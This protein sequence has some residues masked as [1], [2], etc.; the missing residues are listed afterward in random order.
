MSNQPS[1]RKT[2]TPSALRMTQPPAMKTKAYTY[3]V[4]TVNGNDAWALFEACARANVPAATALMKKDRRLVNAQY[5]YR[6][7]IHLAV[8][9]GNAELVELLLE[10]GADPGQSIYTYDSWPKLLQCAQERGDRSVESLLT[11]AM[12]ARFGYDPEFETLKEAIIA[13]D[14]RMI[15]TVLRQQPNL[16]R[17]SDALGNN[18]LHW[19]AITRQ[20]ELIR[21]FVELGTPIDA[22]RA[23]GHT[24]VLLAVNGATDYWHRATRGRSHPSLRNTSVIVGSLLALGADYS[25]S[26]AAAVG[27]Q[28]R[29]EEL[30]RGEPEL[31]T[32]LDSARISPLSHAAREGHLHLVRLLLEHGAEPNRPEEAAP[33]GR[34]LFEACLGNHRQVAELLLERGADPDAGVD[35]SGCCLTIGAVYHGDQAKPIERLLRQ[36]GAQT[37]PYVMSASQ[38]KQAIRDNQEMTQHGEF[39]GCV[40]AKR[41]PALLDL[42]LDLKHG[43]PKGK[44]PARPHFGAGFPYPGRPSLIRQLLDRGLDPNLPDWLGKSFLH[45]SAEQGDRSGAAMLL[46]AGA[47]INAREIEF[48]GTPLAAAVRAWCNETDSEHVPRRRRMVEFLLKRGAATNLPGEAPWSTPL[49]WATRSGKAEIIELLTHHGAT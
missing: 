16:G 29:V 28:E 5:W 21:R 30:L 24:P 45:A 6:F 33:Q 23:D 3:G 1:H 2:R 44:G 17:A 39:L 4:E 36:H 41:D 37:P 11:R 10:N 19:S 49:A 40:L 14:P 38:L 43:S 13:R 18:A 22:K 27:D 15:G 20:L 25:I 32:R 47:D 8:F 46:E 42:Y 31:A 35:S 26:V 7:P 9:A 48:R 12:R 34:A